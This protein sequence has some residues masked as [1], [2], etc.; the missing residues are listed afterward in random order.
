[1][2]IPNYCIECAFHKIVNDRDPHDWF[3]DDDEA[4]LCTKLEPDKRSVLYAGGKLP[5]RMIS[6]SLRPY[7]TPKVIPPAYCPIKLANEKK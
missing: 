4:L 3:N 1:M 2:N 5:H 7:E 6:G